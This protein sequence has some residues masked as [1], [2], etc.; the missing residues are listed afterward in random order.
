MQ[1]RQRDTGAP[2][3]YSR[4]HRPGHSGGGLQGRPLGACADPAA[5]SDRS[6]AINRVNFLEAPPLYSF[7]YP[8]DIARFAKDVSFLRN[9]FLGT[10]SP[11]G[12]VTMSLRSGAP[13]NPINHWGRGSFWWKLLRGRR[14]AVRICVGE[15]FRLGERDPDKSESGRCEAAD[16]IILRLTGLHP[17]QFRSVYAGCEPSSHRLTPPGA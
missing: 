6:I 9:P 10:R 11:G 16:E 1:W 2:G 4:S 3:L 5:R 8:Q 13:I 7:H 17:P 12:V 14:T 15:G